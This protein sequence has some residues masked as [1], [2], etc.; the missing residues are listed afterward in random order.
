MNSNQE[1]LNARV[2]DTISSISDE[3]LL[4]MLK[5]TT[6]DYTPYA[7]AVAREELSKRGGK[8]AIIQ[9]QAKRHTEA[10]PNSPKTI[11]KA[12]RVV[13]E[14]SLALYFTLFKRARFIW[15][16]LFILLSAIGLLASSTVHLSSLLQIQNPLQSV[17][18]WLQTGVFVV[19][20][21][22]ILS[23]YQSSN[24]TNGDKGNSFLRRCSVWMRYIIWGIA[25][26]AFGVFIVFSLSKENI[27]SL[28]TFIKFL[29]ESLTN[30]IEI[31]S[32]DIRLLSVAW[33]VFYSGSLSIILSSLSAGS[34]RDYR[35][36]PNSH[37]VEQLEQYCNECGLPVVDNL[38]GRREGWRKRNTRK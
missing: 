25:F 23:S 1:N 2:R 9:R 38:K 4:K 18:W 7:L 15:T 31:P 12:I 6:R 28:G 34:S 35:S 19:S 16:W 13:H 37:K 33:M 32:E 3:D 20:L 30:E 21:A 22:A 36:C 5:A 14:T 8:E 26:Y 29:F 11:N 24:M 17:T 27:E 10:T